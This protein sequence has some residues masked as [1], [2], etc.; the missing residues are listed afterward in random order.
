[1][2]VADEGLTESEEAMINVVLQSSLEDTFFVVFCEAG[3]SEVTPGTD[4]Q[5][6][7]DLSGIDAQTY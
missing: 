7:D 5:F 3:T 4:F 1:M 2:E 6:K